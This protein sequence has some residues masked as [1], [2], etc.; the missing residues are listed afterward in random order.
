[1]SRSKKKKK[2][3]QPYELHQTIYISPLLMNLLQGISGFQVLYSYLFK[4]L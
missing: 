2:P 1:M 3:H 4:V